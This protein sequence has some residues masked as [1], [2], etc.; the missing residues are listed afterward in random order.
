MK[1]RLL[2]ALLALIL[3]LCSSAYGQ[4]ETAAK[5]K[6]PALELIHVL[7]CKGCHNIDGEG[8]TRAPKLTGI[9]E[10]LTAE[11]IE[12]RLSGHQQTTEG[13]FMPDYRGVPETD[14]ARI[15]DYLYN[16]K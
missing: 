5:P 6:D 16:L 3:A 13:L 4:E 9:G 12:T 14:R 1:L 15:R 10:R 11:Q 2:P 7:G 8:S